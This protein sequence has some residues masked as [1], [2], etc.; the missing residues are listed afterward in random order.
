MR[1]NKCISKKNQE[2]I[3][4]INAAS[5]CGYKN[6]KIA[7]FTR[8]FMFSYFQAWVCTLHNSK[9][10]YTFVYVCSSTPQTQAIHRVFTHFH[11]H[12][13]ACNLHNHLYIV[14]KLLLFFY[15]LFLCGC[16]LTL[17]WP[18]VVLA[19]AQRTRNVKNA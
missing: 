12:N 4:N 10:M 14:Y 11:N 5:K 9:H 17:K 19:V 13:G 3:Y 8:N 16:T 15:F 18:T 2:K 7:E 1:D 6:N